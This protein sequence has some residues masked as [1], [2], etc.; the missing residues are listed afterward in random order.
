[1]KTTDAILLCGLAILMTAGCERTDTTAHSG[2]KTGQT[3]DAVTVVSQPA[4]AVP[5][6]PLLLLDDTE[7]DETESG[8]M[9]DN[10][11]CFVCHINYMQEQI[12]VNHA[13]QN[14]GCAHCH[15]PSDAHIADESWGSGGNGTAPDI[16]YPRDKINPACMTCHPKEKLD[17]PQHELVFAKTDP[18]VC[19]DC[20]GDHRLPQRRCQWR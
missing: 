5:E 9:A 18:K 15:G 4:R 19:T 6:A 1:M 16:M 12:A 7:E 2:I 3:N 17:A 11:R 20:H 10:S 14:I 8:P 13:R